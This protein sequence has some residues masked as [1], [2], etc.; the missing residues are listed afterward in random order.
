[1]PCN[2]VVYNGVHYRSLTNLVN[3]LKPIVT[4]NTIKLRMS[5]KGWSLKKALTTPEMKSQRAINNAIIV[6]G[7]SFRSTKL[8]VEYYNQL[9]YNFSY[10]RIT[11]RLRNGWSPNQAFEIVD[12]HKAKRPGYVYLITNKITNEVYVGATIR[13]LKTRFL[14]HKATS[15]YK[16]TKLYNAMRDYGIENFT[17]RKLK[18][19]KSYRD[20]QYYEQKFIDKYDS[21]NFGYNMIKSTGGFGKRTGTKIKIKGI[22]YY[23]IQAAADAIGVSYGCL[24]KR[25]VT[26]R[27]LDAPIG[28]Y[29]A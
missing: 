7:K 28:R 13:S 22:T 5:R 15:N 14:D 18:T 20:L 16:S 10:S 27:Q 3:V 29:E 19:V 4:L 2:P 12:R 17:I 8:A 1:M 25:I 11:A 9:G 26:G 24:R 23:S 6:A 21:I